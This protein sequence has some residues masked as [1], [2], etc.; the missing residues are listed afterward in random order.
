MT[1]IV[2]SLLGS[3]DVSVGSFFWAPLNLGKHAPAF[4][5]HFI[6]DP[7]HL[8]ELGP[9]AL[10]LL[11]QALGKQNLHRQNSVE[12]SVSLGNAHLAQH[13]EAHPFKK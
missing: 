8:G 7:H 13:R 6:H 11:L 10:A 3:V 5:R 4:E 1:L 12:F 9:V 2:E